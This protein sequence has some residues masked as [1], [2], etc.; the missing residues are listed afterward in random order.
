MSFYGADTHKLIYHPQRVAQWLDGQSVFPLYI[1]VAPAGRCTQRC[2]FCAFDFTQ[3]RG[4]L[5]ETAVLTRALADAAEHGVKAVM[6]AGEGE[7]LLHP[8]IGDLVADAWGSG[9]DV[10]ITTNGVLFTEKLAKTCL[11]YLTWI[12]F[13]LDA[14]TKG[15]YNRIHRGGD[16]DLLKVISNIE[17]AAVIRKR[18]QLSCTIG[19][20]ALLLSE[21]LAEMFDL[22]H[23]VKA[24]G[25][26]YLAIKPYSQHPLSLHHWDI[27]Y[28]QLL[29]MKEELEGL[30]TSSFQ[31]IF[32]AHTMRK[33]AEE[34]PY[35]ECLALPFAT[36]VDASGDVYICSAF[37]GNQ[38]F[39]Y[40]NIY[41]ASFTEIWE[42]LRRQVI[43]RRVAEMGIGLCREVCRLD[44]INRY[45]WQLKNP[46]AHVNFV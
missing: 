31:V 36:Y 19:V 4:P 38:A 33:L 1:E 11:P 32:R 30:S 41:E 35:T 45:L 39:V 27:D 44:E 7:P 25:A 8:D 24:L 13:S 15:T 20:Q 26:D 43:P 40:G 3:Y 42:G 29:G 18:E 5:L 2:I 6:F 23:M 10:A 16:N 37:L 17:R 21:N 28:Q 22:A 14:A 9:L 34:R 12:R 46:P